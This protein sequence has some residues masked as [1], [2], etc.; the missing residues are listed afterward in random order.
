MKQQSSK[1]Q[2]PKLKPLLLATRSLGD[3]TQYQVAEHP[4]E[5]DW[6]QLRSKYPNT[7]AFE[8]R[9][10]M[11]GVPLRAALF[12]LIAFL[13]SKG[14]EF[15]KTLT[16]AEVL[17]FNWKGKLAIIY[18]KSEKELGHANPAGHDAVDDYQASLKKDKEAQQARKQKVFRVPMDSVTLFPTVDHLVKVMLVHSEIL[19]NTKNVYSSMRE[20]LVFKSNLAVFE[21]EFNMIDV[22]YEW[23]KAYHAQQREA[24]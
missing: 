5:Y 24:A 9:Q 14:I 15:F 23:L 7:V 8:H 6:E 1:Q 12:G 2:K 22:Y 20:Y 3:N 19:D 17:K 10:I 21:F 16:G 18:A 11:Q 4:N 13:N